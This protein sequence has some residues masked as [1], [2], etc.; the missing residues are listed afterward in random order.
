MK[1]DRKRKPRTGNAGC[2]GRRPCNRLLKNGANRLGVDNFLG[3]S[4]ENTIQN[5]GDV[6]SETRRLDVIVPARVRI[7]NAYNL[8]C[9]VRIGLGRGTS[10]E[11]SD[12]A[13]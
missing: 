1:R 12:F 11:R 10:T 4:L 3:R 6:N 8:A 5:I 7:D 9:D 2:C 13:P